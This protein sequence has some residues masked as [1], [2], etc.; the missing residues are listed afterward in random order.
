LYN[1]KELQ[2]ELMQYDYGARFYDPVIGRF[3]TIDPLAEKMTRISPY[4]YGFNNPMRF[5]DPD[6]MEPEDIILV[7]TKS[8]RQQ[9]FN[10]LQSLTSQK[11]SLKNDGKVEFSGTPS[12]G[13]KPVG[14][15]LV[16]SLID[17][18]LKIVIKDDDDKGNGTFFTD[19]AAAFGDKDGGSGS[20]ISFNPDNLENSQ[21]GSLNSDGSRGKPVQI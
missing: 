21:Y 16:S 2:E 4:A 10:Q 7:G 19:K 18:D 13:T 6:G 15:D 1:G 3:T 14:T 5:T 20:T 17:S 12:G 11:I 9:V 8:Y